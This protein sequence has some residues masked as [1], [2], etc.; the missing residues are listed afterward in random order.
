MK[1]QIYW[2]LPN[3]FVN[4]VLIIGL[5][6]IGVIL[7]CQRIQDTTTD[8]YTN[9]VI[10]PNAYVQLATTVKAETFASR[11]YV[12]TMTTDGAIALTYNSALKDQVPEEVQQKVEE[13]RQQILAGTLEVPQI[14][15]SAAE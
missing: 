9:A 1:Q 11:L 10:T 2:K 3:R 4:A 13:A 15:F 8:I 7:G 12:F 14:D 6:A 5:L